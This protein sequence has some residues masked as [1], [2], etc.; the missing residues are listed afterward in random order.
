MSAKNKKIPYPPSPSNIPEGFTDYAE[1]FTRKQNFLLAGLFVFLIFYIAMV[2]FFAMVGTWCA[3]TIKHLFL[4]KIAGIAACSIF[5]LYLIKG[6][7][8]RPPMNKEMHLEITED[9]HPILFGFIDQLCEE[10]G[11]PL[12]NK[13][14]V[15]PDVNAACMSRT[16][17]INLFVK[18]KR[19]LL[20][21]LGLVNC[22]N[23][24]EFKAVLAHEFGHFCHL[25]PTNSYAFVVK[26]IIF[27][28]VEG[29]DWLDRFIMWC[30]KQKGFMSAFG[31]V[32]GG[33]LWLG[34]K[35]LWWIL[36]TIALQDRALSREQEFH[37][38]KVAVSA[39]GSDA[40]THGL[41]RARFGM[42]CFIQAINDLVAP[43][44]DHKLYTNDLYLHQ[45]RAAAVVRRQKKEPELGLPPVLPT[46]T[47]GKTTKVFDAEQDEL[48]NQDETPPMWRTHPSDADREENAKKE[49][50][51][52][53]MDHR[54]PWILFNDVAE[55]K[56][57]MTYK[58]YRI[59]FRINKNSDLTDAFK[60]Q[61]YIDNEHAE[62]TYDPKY[63]GA[64]DDRPIE[65][66]DL[67]ELNTIV[68]DSPW[69]EERML[70]VYDKLYEG[71]REHAEAHADLH[72]EN[73]SLQSNVVGKPTPK[74]KKMIA[75]V[76][77]KLEANWEW[78]KS[79]DRRVYLLHIQMATEIDEELRLELIERYRFQLEVQRF[80]QDA[81][82]N[83]NEA[84]A[85]LNVYF[86][87]SRGEV[88]VSRDFGAQV[89]AVLRAAWKALK[90]IV[91]DA[92]EINLPAMKN[93][94]EGE[95]LADFILEGK[96]VP[97]PPLSELKGVWVQKL[98][99]Q[100]QGVKNRC[101][102]LHFK[103]VGGVLAVQEK[104]ASKWLE[105][106]RPIEA[107]VIPA[108]VIEAEVI[109]VEV[110]PVEVVGDI[111][112]AEV[113]PAEVVDAREEPLP[114]EE[115][116]VEVVPE[117]KVPP[118]S[119]KPAMAAYV[120][121]PPLS[122]P[123]PP[124][125][126]ASVTGAKTP[127]PAAPQSTV[128]PL[129]KEVEV[130][131]VLDY[132]P[133]DKKKPIEVTVESVEGTV[134][135]PPLSRHFNTPTE[136]ST[137]SDKA[138]AAKVVIPALPDEPLEALEAEKQVAF[139]STQQAPGNISTTP[140]VTL[141]ESISK[142]EVVSQ[143]T[144]A[145]LAALEAE[146]PGV[147]DAAQSLPETPVPASNTLTVLPPEPEVVSQ[148]TPNRPV[149]SETDKPATFDVSHSSPESMPDSVST[150]NA[151]VENA[152]PS[153]TG[154]T[155]ETPSLAAA[156]QLPAV[157]ISQ[158]IGYNTSEVAT[159]TNIEL[160][161]PKTDSTI[162]VVPTLPAPG[163]EPTP[164]TEENNSAEAMKNNPSTNPK[165]TAKKPSAE[166][167]IPVEEIFS[168]DA[169]DA[170]AS[171]TTAKTSPV[172]EPIPVEEIFSLDSDDP[173]VAQ[174]LP[175]EELI[176]V[177]EV[178]SL[179]SDDATS[180]AKNAKSP[181]AEEPIPAEE[182]FTLN[183]EEIAEAE[184]IDAEEVAEAEF[185][186]AE[187]VAEAEFIDAEEIA[188][189]EFIDAEEIEV[190]EIVE[191]E[192]PAK[193]KSPPVAKSFPAAPV[194]PVAKPA[195]IPKAQ[196]SPSG[197]TSAPA[198]RPA[199]G[200]AKTA[201]PAEPATNESANGTPTPSPSKLKRP[202]VKITLVK[203]GEKSPFAK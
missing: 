6:F 179:D 131:E 28:L 41:L 97:E 21:G 59:E 37:A 20:I 24:S 111:I 176:P 189:A 182:V 98:M 39:A 180:S 162:T 16:S 150:I 51:P 52:A 117:T 122:P 60:M 146:K 123:P 149:V 113:I 103:S 142:P 172:E 165:S 151:E 23:L 17:L 181:P 136:V 99:N 70:K 96:M 144:V 119:S 30:K 32:I 101:F 35:I 168:L 167:P 56:E 33:C 108:E 63:H 202:T 153:V 86:A 152:F 15:S 137:A 109:P 82:K 14:Y 61:E 1:T 133:L 196:P 79:F 66:G 19:D 147:D 148:P 4:L 116:P 158:E 173:P 125:K 177:E 13:V 126:S 12:P 49:F 145:P 55:L 195:A 191:T 67:N 104:I 68:R 164:Q 93:F 128:P 132:F 114:L 155:I 50:I 187:E 40:S 199:F 186:D 73:Q 140:P 194:Q 159:A 120:S 29:E 118:E 25:G 95:R 22:M 184:F 34:R 188:E 38:D 11:A 178:F 76:E 57:R 138:S 44:R 64:Y 43:A 53:A 143:P 85:H 87:A 201:E 78:F 169:D 129:P 90:K 127:T 112:E 139:D 74:L 69:T 171:A 105:A 89:I 130:A 81:R 115:I 107:E 141:T 45:D 156:E 58:F 47:S 124:T 83:F 193:P 8:K 46:P 175:L 102:R 203:P 135:P 92:R 72:K 157:P 84:D 54:S 27:D 3:L 163:S 71:C 75:E 91:Q 31:L 185:I 100:L 7:F 88:Q 42:Q 106:H 18:P 36:K 5:F 48:E 121:A 183:A 198:S 190:A 77:K 197:T 10:L 65:P 166:E 154:L 9:E 94:E 110:I 26:R 62:T 161:F 160:T 134:Q 192:E 174:P 80:Y 2:I 200:S 170:H